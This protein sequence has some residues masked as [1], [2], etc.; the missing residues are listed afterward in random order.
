MCVFHQS[1][2]GKCVREETVVDNGAVECMTQK[3]TPES[4]RGQTRTCAERN[5]I[6]EKKKKQG[7]GQ[8]EYRSWYSATRIPHRQHEGTRVEWQKHVRSGYD[9]LLG[10]RKLL[11]FGKAEVNLPGEDFTSPRSDLADKPAGRGCNDMTSCDES[12]LI[13]NVDGRCKREQ[14]A[15]K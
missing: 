4:R 9:E 5:E 15:E 13:L 3:Q 10:S 1:D 7:N 12:I 8:L 6:F 11:G 2:N 14:D